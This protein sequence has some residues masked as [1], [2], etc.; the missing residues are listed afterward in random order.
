MM[1]TKILLINGGPSGKT[2]GFA[3]RKPEQSVH[4]LDCLGLNKTIIFCV[5][6]NINYNL[7]HFHHFVLIY[8]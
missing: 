8:S 2:E 3:T 1:K 5:N 4:T 6:I 7:H